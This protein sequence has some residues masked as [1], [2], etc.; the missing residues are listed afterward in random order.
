MSDI[1]ADIIADSN[2]DHVADANEEV[3]AD[4]VLEKGI[5][6]CTSYQHTFSQRCG[7][8]THSHVDEKRHPAVQAA[9]ILEAGIRTREHLEMDTTNES[10]CILKMHRA[11][12][13][14]MTNS[15]VI[16]GEMKASFQKIEGTTDNVLNGE[17]ILKRFKL[18]KGKMMNAIVPLLPKN[19]H[20]IPS[21]KDHWE[22]FDRVCLIIC[23]KQQ[24]ASLVKSRRKEKIAT[25][26]SNEDEAMK[27]IDE[28]TAASVPD[29]WTCQKGHP[30]KLLLSMK[31][32][33]NSKAFQRSSAE[34]ASGNV[35]SAL[36]PV[37]GRPQAGRCIRL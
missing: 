8:W 22:A 31:I 3:S 21:G 28:L 10:N 26:P 4:E 33:Y 6:D 7:H 18:F 17:V 29:G 13:K 19:I 35:T 30:E 2:A 5:G 14:Q 25:P 16:P 9:M 11:L 32:F 36:G 23:K 27:E 24:K 15:N 12:L 37:Q 20:D 1:I 34:G